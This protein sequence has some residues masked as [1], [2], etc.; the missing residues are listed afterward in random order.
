MYSSGSTY[1]YSYCISSQSMIASDS[2]SPD[3]IDG[4]DGSVELDELATG[5]VNFIWLQRTVQNIEDIPPQS[6]GQSI[7]HSQY[8]PTTK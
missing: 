8:S 4:C 2:F 6:I 5:G 7:V 3:V 1:P